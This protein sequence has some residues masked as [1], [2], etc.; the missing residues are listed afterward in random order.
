MALSIVFSVLTIVSFLVA[1]YFFV[2][3]MGVFDEPADG[4]F[5]A[6]QKREFFK[7]GHMACIIT[8]VLAGVDLI[9]AAGLPWFFPL[10]GAGI[11]ALLPVIAWI[12]WLGREVGLTDP[13]PY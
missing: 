11:G 1:L 8:G 7:W 6:D 5:T 9:L 2:A 10:V 3:T 12:V 13:R 4:E